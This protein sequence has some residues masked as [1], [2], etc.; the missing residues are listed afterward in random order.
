MD[1]IRWLHLSDFHFSASMLDDPYDAEKVIRPLLELIEQ[2]RQAD[3]PVDLLFITGDIGNHGKERDYETTR[4]YFDRLIA[5]AGVPKDSLWVVPGNHDVDRAPGRALR[6]TLDDDQ[7]ASSWFFADSVNRANHLSKFTSYR[8]FIESYFPGRGFA[9]GDVVHRPVVRVLSGTGLGIL[10]LNSAWFAQGD[11]DRGKL[12]IGS[13][14]VRERAE[15]LRAAGAEFVVGLFHH[16]LSELH[17]NDTAGAWIRNQC[18]FFLRGHLHSANVEAIVS[19]DGAV[20]EI[21]AGASYQGSAWPCRAFYG[22][23][24]VKQGSITLDPIRYVDSAAT[25]T[26]TL[27]VEAFPGRAASGYSATYQLPLPVPVAGNRF[28]DRFPHADWTAVN[29]SDWL[30]AIADWFAGSY[31]KSPYAT[32]TDLVAHVSAILDNS[33]SQHNLD[34]R[35]A[36][37]GKALIPLLPVNDAGIP[38]QLS[39]HST[40]LQLLAF[41]I[42][43]DLSHLFMLPSIDL[44]AVLDVPDYSRLLLATR[45]LG[46]GEYR[47]ASAVASE[48]GPGCCV[49]LYV[50]AQC[51]RKMELNYEAQSKFEGLER[52]VRSIDD[53]REQAYPCSASRHVHCL[54]NRDLLRASLE[55]ASGVVARRLGDKKIAER[56]FSRAT[57]AA[58]RAVKALSADHPGSGQDTT[59]VTNYDRSPYEVLADVHYSHGY[60]WYEQANLE[61]A[62]ALFQLSIGALAK[63][64]S[65]DSWDSP[66]T[67]LAIVYF[68]QDNLDLATSYALRARNICK[69]TPGSTNREGLLSLALNTLTLRAIEARTGHTL[70]AADD[71]VLL[72][73]EAA[74]ALAPPLALGPLSC[75][76]K[77]AAILL[78][79]S[80]SLEFTNL[81]RAFIDRL[82]AAQRAIAEHGISGRSI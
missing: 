47:R 29:R 45:F 41:G 9:P 31:A 65:P 58:R 36:N 16:P 73:L 19:D 62:S 25:T 2:R 35:V 49:A 13:R 44:A 56:H 17:E 51:D 53:T 75:H 24:D 5:A 34:A 12:W 4:G 40:V 22:N 64:E 72:E 48:I 69:S 82:E 38:A 6:R 67:R 50:M 8:Q 10:P 74:L 63:S 59:L 7:E 76:A 57:T 20:I 23:L 66:Y 30:P 80:E 39:H 26:W 61:K 54:C 14:L 11:D 79:K 70:I 33:K 18:D 78:G 77:D 52:L 3:G 43:R 60:Y 81:A 21:A 68:T 27:D 37:L 42:N 1:H 71:D 28:T 55:R 46:A 15:S 32:M